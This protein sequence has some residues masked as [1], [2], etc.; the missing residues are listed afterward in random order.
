MPL[1]SQP[2]SQPASRPPRR[3]RC[4]AR[5]MN[6]APEQAGMQLESTQKLNLTSLRVASSSSSLSEFQRGAARRGARAVM[7]Y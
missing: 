4:V 5:E 7:V 1:A 6:A 3:L 2:A